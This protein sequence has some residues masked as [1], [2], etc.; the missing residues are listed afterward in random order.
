MSELVEVRLWG[1]RIGILGYPPEGGPAAFEYDSDF[2]RSGIQLSPVVMPCPPRL[3]RFTGI[4]E[5]TFKGLPGIFADSLPDSFGNKLIDLF[6]AERGISAFRITALDR[7]LY[8][9][10]RGMGALEYHPA[11]DFSDQPQTSLALDI[12]SLTE[13]ASTIVSRDEARRSLLKSTSLH[14]VIN[15]IRIGSSAGGARAKALVARTG[16]GRLVDGSGIPSEEHSY[17]ILKFDVDCNADRDSTDAM[18][19]PRVEYIYSILA[20]NCGIDMPE[21]DFVED[22][23]SFHFLIRR[24]DRFGAH[25]LHY[26]SWAALAH[27]DRDSTGVYSYEQLVL[28]ARQLGLG[29]DSC[30]ELFRRAVFNIIG[31]NQDDHTK[32]FGFLMDRSGTW[33]LSPAFDMVWS[34]DPTGSWTRSHQIRLN[35]K[36]DGFTRNDLLA[37]GRYCNLNASK[38]GR[39]I[40]EVHNAFCT[41]LSYAQQYEVH[42]ALASTIEKTLR[43]DVVD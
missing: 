36:Q 14:E 7:L 39:I 34:F 12:R 24:F 22:G 3:H 21:T 33:R 18:G 17:W 30:T 27:A 26:A 41:F 4:S 8:V 32:N 13:L 31:R 40:D 11:R 23:S 5:Q 42:S 10:N 1:S 28:L 29:Q 37:F 20:R 2:A 15:L 25:K 19:M 16:E 43:M 6:L 35:R 9:G 38:A